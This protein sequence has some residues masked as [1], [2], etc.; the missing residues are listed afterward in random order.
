MKKQNTKQENQTFSVYL[1][2][3]I[4]MI[5]GRFI[6]HKYNNNSQ[7]ANINIYSSNIYAIIVLL[8][9]NTTYCTIYKSYKMQNDINKGKT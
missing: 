6:M 3:T 5:L 2:K 8:N 1:H 9:Y 7:T 4:G